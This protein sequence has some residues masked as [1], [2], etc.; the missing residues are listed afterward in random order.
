MAVREAL[1]NI[2]LNT[3]TDIIQST[4]VQSQTHLSHIL[5][6]E[7]DLKQYDLAGSSTG[8][9]C[10][11]CDRKFDSARG[12]L[13]HIATSKPHQIS[14]ISRILAS[15][16]P[17]P[18]HIQLK[19]NGPPVKKSKLGPLDALFAKA[20]HRTPSTNKNNPT[21]SAIT[22]AN[23]YK[24]HDEDDDGSVR[25]FTDHDIDDMFRDNDSILLNEVIEHCTGWK[26]DDLFHKMTP[27]I[28]SK[29][30]VSIHG[31]ALHHVSC[32]LTN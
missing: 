10:E 24:D 7:D 6:T 18:S 3:Y 22:V 25:S 13:G 27:F 31:N 32:K 4:G 5:F 28:L 30:T 9:F 20:K 15:N 16:K 1:Q 8:S 14:C 2:D 26:V 29:Y 23:E 21:A 19:E 12:Y 11:V 17:F